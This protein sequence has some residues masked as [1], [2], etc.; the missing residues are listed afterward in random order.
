MI[1]ETFAGGL[2]LSVVNL[3]VVFAVLILIALV[4]NIIYKLVS[5]SEGGEKVTEVA[6]KVAPEIASDEVIPFD[7]LDSRRK[8]VIAAALCAYLGHHAVSVFVRRVPDAGA[9]G[10]ASRADAFK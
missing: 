9:W 8:A 10:K 2:I 4:I 1:P 6:P 5:K 3:T 7:S